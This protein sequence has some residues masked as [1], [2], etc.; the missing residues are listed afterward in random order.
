VDDIVGDKLIRIDPKSS[1]QTVV[2]H[3]GLPIGVQSVEV[4]GG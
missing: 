2:A 4:F 3:G 1:A